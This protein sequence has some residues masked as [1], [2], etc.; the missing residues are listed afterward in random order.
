MRNLR[1]IIISLVTIALSSCNADNEY[2]TKYSCYFLFYTQYHTTSNIISAINPLA[3]GTFVKI[4]LKRISNITHVYV[5]GYGVS[6]EDTQLTTDKENYPYTSGLYLGANNSIIVGYSMYGGL[7]AYDGQ[8][9]NCLESSS[10]TN[11]PLTWDN[12][13]QS[14]KCSKCGRCYNLSTGTVSSGNAGIQ[15]LKYRATYDGTALIVHN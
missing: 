6:N 8:C 13:G 14:V 9:P 3:P 15:L 4:S 1:C 2:C 12:S 11:F 10:S 5:Y 7:C